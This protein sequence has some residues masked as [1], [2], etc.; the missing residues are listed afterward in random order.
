MI[1]GYSGK[2]AG[3]TES[4][5]GF[6]FKVS[7]FTGRASHSAAAPHL[8]IN[9]LYAAN[10]ALS[11]LNAQKD[12]YVDEEHVRVHSV[13]EILSPAV[14]V[15]PSD[16]VME[17][18]V[19]AGTVNA[20]LDAAKKTDRALK[21]GA[22]ALGA[23]VSIQTI[24][25]YMPTIQNKSLADIYKKNVIPFIPGEKF[26]YNPP[27][28]SST[29]MGDVSQIMPAIHPYLGGWSGDVHGS[30][31]EISDKYLAYVV[32]AKALALCAIDLLWDDAS[33]AKNIMRESKPSM[34][35]K[36]YLAIQEKNFNKAVYDYGK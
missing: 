3:I 8:G 16:V 31:F 25:G 5:N 22:L 18:Q 21:S 30:N 29:D 10:H 28:A 19:R 4:Y 1:H 9:A 13:F 12:T 24:P 36:E 26:Y 11:A 33:L 32:P 17:T 15:V 2:A 14:N 34:T 20:I 35:K 27:K 23:K 6:I 7:N